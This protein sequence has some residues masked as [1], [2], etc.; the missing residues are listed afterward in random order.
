MPADFR[1]APSGYNLQGPDGAILVD[2]RTQGFSGQL[3][4]EFIDRNWVAHGR[5][6]GGARKSMSAKEAP[7]L[8]RWPSASSSA[9]Q[10]L[11]EHDVCP[12]GMMSRKGAYAHHPIEKVGFIIRVD[13]CDYRREHRSPYGVSNEEVRNKILS[14]AGRAK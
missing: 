1:S 2:Y 14:S 5:N 8:Q 3:T 7:F 4:S 9:V 11:F 12:V 13:I 6:D 10:Y